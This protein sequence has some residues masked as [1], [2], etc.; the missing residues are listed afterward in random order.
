MSD[1]TSILKVFKRNLPGLRNLFIK[2]L[3][4]GYSINGIRDIHLTIL[5]KGNVQKIT[6]TNSPF[7]QS[8]F[9]SAI[10]QRISLWKFF[11]APQKQNVDRLFFQLMLSHKNVY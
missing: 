5:P 1:R 11:P 4:G 7:P 6:I 3:V 2:H 9:N 8:D 10:I